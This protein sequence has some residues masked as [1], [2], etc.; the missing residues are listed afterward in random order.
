MRSYEVG[1]PAIREAMQNLQRMGLIEI[2]HGERPRVAEPSFSRTV[3]Q[4]GDTM[5]HLLKHSPANL[6]HLKEARVAFDMEMARLAARKHNDEDIAR[7]T[8]IIDS[9]EACNPDTKDFLIYDGHFHRE[10]AAI[11]GNPIFVSLSE[12]L[13]SWLAHFHVD[14][15]RKSGLEKLTIQ[16]HRGVL[17][18]IER[19]DQQAAAKTMSDHLNRANALYHREN[20]Q[21]DKLSFLVR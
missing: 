21:P 6:E 17:A 14:L 10:I 8:K 13:F 5:R 12:A 2:K 4:L 19:G 18:A 7:L 3:E 11:S 20:D 15:V 16:E 1:R 9:Q